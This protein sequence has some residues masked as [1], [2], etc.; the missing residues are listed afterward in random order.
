[1]LLAQKPQNEMTATEVLERVEEKLILLGPTMGRLQQEFYNPLLS[2]VFG[3][4]FEN[5]L[6]APPPR[7]LAG[8]GLQIEYISKLALAMRK[9]ETDAMFKT[10]QFVS[11]FLQIDPS[12]IDNFN[13]DAISKGG[14]E[15]FGLPTDWFHTAD[16]VRQ[17][18]TARAKKQ[19]Q[20]EADQ[21]ALMQAEAAGKTLPAL[22]KNVEPDSIFAKQAGATVQ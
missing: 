13:L 5:G 18:R 6:V 12:I 20:V 19:A 11:P 9:F 14:A 4:M 22:T 3:I 7:E 10:V 8:A 2:N 21:K 17:I 1:M 15:R 16:T